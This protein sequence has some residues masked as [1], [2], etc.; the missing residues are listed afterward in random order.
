MRGIMMARKKPLT[1]ETAVNI[2]ATSEFIEFEMPKAK[3]AVKMIDAENVGELF[4]LLHE[5]AKVL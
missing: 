2:E 5:E 4:T 3:P 1:V